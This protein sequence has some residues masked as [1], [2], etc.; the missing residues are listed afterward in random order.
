MPEKD[1]GKRREEMVEG[2]IEGG[3]LES[4]SK[5]EQAMRKVPR[6]VFVPEEHIGDSYSD[7]ALPVPPMSS[8]NQTISAPYTYPLFYRPLDLREGETFLEIGAGSG[9]GA[10]LAEELVGE[11]GKVV[12]VEIEPETYRF[13]RENLGEAGYGGVTVLEGDGSKGC[14]GNSP[15]DKVSITAATPSFPDPLREQLATPGKMVAPIGSASGNVSPLRGGQDLTLLERGP[16]GEERT[17][18]IERVIYVPLKGEHG[19]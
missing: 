8:R 6:E 1:F 11:S 5:L 17:R 4:G 10:A 19:V 13:A 14:P 7:K 9:Y 3:L 2:Y 12:T 18:K 16:G 15:F